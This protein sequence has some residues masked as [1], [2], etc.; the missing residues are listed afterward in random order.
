MTVVC[1]VASIAINKMEDYLIQYVEDKMEGRSRLE[2]I[3]L[4]DDLGYTEHY[5]GSI[6]VNISQLQGY[7]F[8]M[9]TQVCSVRDICD[10]IHHSI[11]WDKLEFELRGMYDNY[12]EILREQRKEEYGDDE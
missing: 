8:S 10:V 5:G 12:R 4:W 9:L 3:E 2:Q 7:V 6:E 1:G 11:D